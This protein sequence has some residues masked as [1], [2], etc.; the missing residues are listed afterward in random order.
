MAVNSPCAEFGG[1]LGEVGMGETISGDR[2]LLDAVVDVVVVKVE[3]SVGESVSSSTLKLFSID[4][5]SSSISRMSLPIPSGS[6]TLFLPAEADGRRTCPL[7]MDGY[8][9]AAMLCAK[10][11]SSS[12]WITSTM[13]PRYRRLVDMLLAVDGFLDK[14]PK[15]PKPEPDPE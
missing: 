10:S 8:G 9:L 3:W 14:P 5:I 13:S 2:A 7:R 15:P 6:A 12:S 4:I 11:S 1:R